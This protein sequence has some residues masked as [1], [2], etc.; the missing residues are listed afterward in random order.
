VGGAG[1]DLLIGGFRANTLTGGQG[2]DIFEFD[3]KVGGLSLN[4][5]HTIKDFE[6][7]ADKIRIV[8]YDFGY[9]YNQSPDF[10]LGTS[11]INTRPTIAYDRNTGNL[12]YDGDG[13]NNLFFTHLFANLE[14]KPNLSFRTDFTFQYVPA[15]SINRAIYV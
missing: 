12:F 14:N 9:D 7:G 4:A 1:K 2:A 6:S 3:N 5:V 10:I 11:A 13:T 15:P 8:E